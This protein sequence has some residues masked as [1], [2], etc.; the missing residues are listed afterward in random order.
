MDH[1]DFVIVG[2]GLAGLYAAFRASRY[3]NVAL[4][5]KSKVR[6]SNSYFAQGGIAAVIDEE[7]T[8]AFHFEDT[9]IAGRGLCDHTAVDILVNEGPQRIAELVEEGMNFDMFDGTFALGLE[10][11]H[12]KRRILHA[13]GDVTGK[14]ITDFMIEKVL[15]CKNINLFENHSAIEILT[16]KDICYGV[17]VWNLE[18]NS[19]ELFLGTS[20]ILTLGGASAIYKRTSNPENTTGDGIALAY[21]A[22]CQLEDMEFIQF[23]PT[24]LYTDSEK[25]FLISEAVRGEGAYLINQK[26]ERFMKDVHE[27][28]ELA[29]RDVVAQAIF[30]E[31]SNQKNPYVHLSLSHLDPLRIQERFPNIFEKCRVLGIDMRDR[32]PVAPAAHYMV[33][34]VKTDSNGKTNIQNLYVCGELASTGIM[35]ANRLASNSLIEC[36]VF[37]YRAIEFSKDSK[38]EFTF[39]SYKKKYHINFERQATYQIL[40][41]KVAAIMT[42]YAGIIRNQEMLVNAYTLLEQE[43]SKLHEVGSEY[44][45]SIGNNLIT[46]AQLIVASAIYRKES[47]GGHFRDDFRSEDTSFLFHIIQ[48]KGREISTIPVINSSIN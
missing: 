32:V 40:K 36:L 15:S 5:T 9:I 1:Y 4:V 24:T 2:S 39:P 19:E 41:E 30:R 35:G 10:G 13:G 7:D 38:S 27:N 14:K 46:V 16:E 8:P 20:T 6:D 28:A 43:K 26:G 47:R 11:G 42:K 37:G 17:R 22:N 45:D 44:Y 12:H 3:G 21:S 29:P 48:Q 31:I 18:T 33:G 25:S 34:G 23:H